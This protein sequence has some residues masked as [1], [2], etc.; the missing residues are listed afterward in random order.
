MPLGTPLIAEEFADFWTAN[1]P[2]NATTPTGF[3]MEAVEKTYLWGHLSSGTVMGA[4]RV[5]GGTNIQFQIIFQDYGTWEEYEPGEFVNYENLQVLQEGNIYWRFSRG[6][7][8]WAEQELLLN[9]AITEGRAEFKFQAF[10]DL[11]YK[12]EAMLNITAIN[13][14]EKALWR[15]G[16]ATTMEGQGP[17]KKEP[18]SIHY[19]VNEETNGLVSGATTVEGLTPSATEVLGPDGVSRWKPQQETYTSSATDN[20]DNILAAF[21]DMFHAVE[22]QVP[23]TR[24]EFFESPRLNKQL[25]ITSPRGRAIFMQLLRGKQDHF[26]AGPQDPAYPDPQFMGI[27]VTRS[28]HFGKGAYYASG[29]TEFTHASNKGPRY[30]WLNGNYLFP[31]IHRQRSF[32]RTAPRTQFNVPDVWAVNMFVWW[33]L[34]N[35]SRQRQGIVSPVGNIYTA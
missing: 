24:S 28:V 15:V 22:F 10:V 3:I 35:T 20:A 18:Y 7:T 19:F 4:E 30:L 29:T 1:G 14:L 16:N 32:Y 9:Q 13:G 12:K 34:L 25:I 2:A 21:D 8:A 17:G 27:P 6:H 33:N 5:Q 23:A 11:Q 31:V 26:I